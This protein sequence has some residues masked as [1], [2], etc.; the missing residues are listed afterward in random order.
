[1]DRHMGYCP[2]NRTVEELHALVDQRYLQTFSVGRVVKVSIGGDMI[3]SE[4]Q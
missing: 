3:R 2:T 4:T 1:M